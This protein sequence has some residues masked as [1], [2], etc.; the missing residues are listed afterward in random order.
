MRLPSSLGEM[1][2]EAVLRVTKVVE[3][4]NVPHRARDLLHEFLVNGPGRPAPEQERPP[5]Q[6]GVLS[7][8]VRVRYESPTLARMGLRRL[9]DAMSGVVKQQKWRLRPVLWELL[10]Q[11]GDQTPEWRV[12][13]KRAVGPI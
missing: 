5:L 1:E 9:E 7:R 13:F 3:L 12:D 2:L 4:I 8:V 6:Q 11:T 10:G